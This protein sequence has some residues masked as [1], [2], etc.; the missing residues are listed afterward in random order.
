[1]S[2]ALSWNLRQRTSSIYKL[3][4]ILDCLLVCGYL[5]LLVDW[6]QVPWSQ[7]YTWLEAVVFVASFISFHYFQLYRSWRG[8]KLYLEFFV[9]LKAW[10]AVVGILL[11]YFFICKVSE[12]YSRAIFIV[13][14]L[15]TPLLLFLSHLAV[16]QL[17]RHYRAQGKNIR[18]AVVIGAGELGVRMAQQ[19][20]A[21]PWAG[22]EVLGF[23]DDKLEQKGHLAVNKPLLGRIR[24]LREYLMVNDIDYVYIA[25][26]MRAERKIFWILRECRDL[27]AQLYLVPDLYIFGLHHAEIQ[28][29]GEMLVLSFNPDHSWK[30]SFDIVFSL[31]ILILTAPLMF[32]IML[33]I[34]LDSRGPVIYRHRRIT[35]TGREFECLKFRTMVV[36]ADKK[37]HELLE[38]DSAL[39]EEWRSTFKLKHDPRVTRM[40]RFLRRSSLD[41]FPQFINVLKGEMSVVGARPIVGRELEEYYKGSG[42]PSAGRYVSMKPGITGLWQVSKR[43]DTENYQERIELDDWYVLNHS[44][45]GDLKIIL[46]TVGC[47]ISGKGAY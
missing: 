27:G 11:F 25:L 34:K 35:A 2:P 29:I 45:V 33:L 23:F 21:I 42:G 10:A 36:D 12:G 7:Y 22:I 40:G 47:M 3:L 18:H 30:R 26:P 24:D 4:H 9:I 37:L 6:H 20:E 43:S 46:K 14:S 39:A 44:L 8:W 28:S 17:L 15:T 38:R 19:T 13:W 32:L 1:M 16:R 41:E 31:L 5:S